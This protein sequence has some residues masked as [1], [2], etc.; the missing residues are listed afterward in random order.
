MKDA[1]QYPLSIFLSNVNASEPGLA[2]ACGV[3]SMGVVLL[4]FLFFE[5]E[6]V[7]GIEYVNFK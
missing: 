7:T 1:S 4:L 6:L 3:L 2:F 5:E